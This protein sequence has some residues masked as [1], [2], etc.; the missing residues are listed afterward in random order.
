MLYLKSTLS[1]FWHQKLFSKTES[2]DDDPC[3]RKIDHALRYIHGRY[4]AY[5]A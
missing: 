4:E 3:H 1:I 5:E 2:E